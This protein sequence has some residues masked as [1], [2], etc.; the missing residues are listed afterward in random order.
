MRQF[1]V[2]LFVVLITV[3]LK[4]KTDQGASAWETEGLVLTDVGSAESNGFE[5]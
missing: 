3:T 2:C 4:T 1:N 5:F